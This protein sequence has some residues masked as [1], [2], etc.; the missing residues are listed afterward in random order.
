MVGFRILGP[1]ESYV[2]ERRVALGGP[3]QLS[4]LAFMLVHANRAVSNDALIEAVWGGHGPAGAV[5]R[6]QVAVARLRRALDSDVGSAGSSPLRT[7]A[8]GYLLAVAPGELDAWVFEARL[9]EGLRALDAGDHA[10]AAGVLRGALALWRG[11]ALAE[12][13][14]EEFALPEVR[15]LEELR[16]V[17]L[18]ARLDAD[19]RLGRTDLIAELQA[20]FARHPTRERLAGQL[21]RALYGCGRQAE[22][23]DVYQRIRVQLTGELGIEPGP[24]LKELQASIL[25]HAPTL[26]LSPAVAASPTGPAAASTLPRA[27]TRLIGRRRE[28]SAVCGLLRE[29]ARLV[30]LTGA[31]GAGKTRLALAVA[32]ELEREFV[33]G[34]VFIELA[35]VDNPKLLGE[36]IADALDVSGDASGSP[37]SALRC[38]LRARNLLLVLD[39]FERILPA[40]T[41]VAELLQAA[42]GVK[43]IVTSRAALHIQ[44]EQQFDVP[45]LALP[46]DSELSDLERLARCEAVAL[47]T[48]RARARNPTF[49]LTAAN[50]PSVAEICRRLDGLPLALELAAVWTK[51]L[52]P[53][54]LLGRLQPRLG[55]LVDGAGDLPPRHQTLR[56]TIEWSARLLAP[57]ERRLFGRVAVFAGGCTVHTA[58]RVCG[59]DVDV[60]RGLARLVDHSL[61][62]EQQTAGG[63]RRFSMLET[64]REYALELLASNDEEE[65]IRQRHAEHLRQLVEHAA[66]QLWGP[67]HA[68]WLQ[69]LSLELDNIRAALTWCRRS[70][71]AETALGLS[72]AAAHFWQI[73]GY[74]SEGRAWLEEALSLD[75]EQAPDLRAK[76]LG[77]SSVL[78]RMQGD[79]ALAHRRAQEALAASRKLGDLDGVAKALSDLAAVAVGQHQ[80]GRAAALHDESIALARETGGAQLGISLT[81]RADL[82]LNQADYHRA[83]ELSKESVDLFRAGGSREG[84]A[85]AL[86]NWASAALRQGETSQAFAPFVR[87]LALSADIGYDQYIA[88]SL[89]GLAAIFAGLGD[90]ATAT[91]LLAAGDRICQAISACREPA[92]RDLFRR[93]VARARRELGDDAFTAEWQHGRAMS[94]QQAIRDATSATAL[95]RAL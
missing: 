7:V 26:A 74:L 25:Q 1:I 83:I 14:Y 38:H 10:G 85:V 82:A 64:V 57:S 81:N 40:A 91:R 75:A 11:R 2:A 23:L 63:P 60:L 27:P 32:A 3:R 35:A 5:K 18:E 6:V 20:L 30:T 61:L 45:P 34:V 39:N 66:A 48:E 71:A 53:P 77:A 93:T 62:R 22:A 47:F 31:G 88:Y 56:A 69:Q 24:A 72:A 76:A 16:L 90:H 15:R 52:D 33:D 59:D 70:G 21:M 29:G 9:A 65:L 19:L 12:V 36:T 8:G 86:F 78:A 55:L 49:E 44:S 50:A 67:Q 94:R 79:L 51:M 28:T 54:A 37:A 68:A 41:L 13:A 43:T 87:S 73:R 46:A 4:L 58:E 42:P 89:E 92:E 95:N 80:Y 17:G 84:E